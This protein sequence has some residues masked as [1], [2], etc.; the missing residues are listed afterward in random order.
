MS[1]F[2]LQIKQEKMSVSSSRAQL[3]GGR[4]ERRKEKV[5]KEGEKGEMPSLAP[6]VLGGKEQAAKAD[7]PPRAGAARRGVPGPQGPRGREERPLHPQSSQGV[8]AAPRPRTPSIRSL[9]PGNGP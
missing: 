9:L 7:K 8:L 3:P 1:C 6:A 4:K 2:L 5:R